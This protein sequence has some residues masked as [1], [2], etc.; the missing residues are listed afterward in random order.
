MRGFVPLLLPPACPAGE[1]KLGRRKRK[2]VK[3]SLAVL[4]VLGPVIAWLG[5]G[6]YG[7][8][9]LYRVGKEREAHVQRIKK[10]T[11]ENQALFDEI[12]RLRK[13]P[14]YVERVARKELGLVKENE[15]IYRFQDDKKREAEP[16]KIMET[17]ALQKDTTLPKR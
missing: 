5:F 14:K 1:V 13:D 9:H 12:Q 11:E 17:K 6:Q 7:F 15:V 2:L 16:D 8:I 3:I 4:C 10:L